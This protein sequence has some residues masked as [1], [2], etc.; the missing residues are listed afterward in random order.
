MYEDAM[1]DVAV[2]KEINRLYE[3]DHMI[4]I[5]T[6]RGSVSGIDHTQLTK[7]Q[8]HDW[9]VKYNELIMNKKP[10]ADVYIDD[11]AMH[12]D[13]WKKKNCPKRGVLA[14][15]F[16]LI[17]PGYIKMFQEAKQYCEHL[18]VLLHIDPSINGKFLPVHTV[19]ERIEILQELRSVD[20]ILIYATEDDLYNQ[21]KSDNYDI[22]FLGS[23]YF[24]KG[25]T[26]IDLKIPVFWIERDHDYSTT[27]LKQKISRSM[28]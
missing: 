2:V 15:A 27:A 20:R 8:L 3:S 22:R 14:G 25:Y 19:S 24:N 5:M 28:P 18:T 6:A 9:G 1:P 12:I 4:K 10:Y 11:R 26:G 21:L 13:D 7:R 16:D 17:H 23:D